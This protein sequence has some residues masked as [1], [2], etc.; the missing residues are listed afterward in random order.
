[1]PPQQTACLIDGGASAADTCSCWR[2]DASEW[3]F[4]FLVALSCRQAA[5]A[6]KI[7]PAKDYLT[8][9]NGVLMEEHAKGS[10]VVQHLA[11]AS[12]SFGKASHGDKLMRTVARAL[13]RPFFCCRR[14]QATCG[15]VGGAA[16]G[17]ARERQKPCSDFSLASAQHIAAAVAAAPEAEAFD[18]AADQV[19]ALAELEALAVPTGKACCGG[20]WWSAF[21]CAVGCALVPHAVLERR[22]GWMRLLG[23]VAIVWTAIAVWLTAS[24]L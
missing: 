21:H 6:T 4:L 22:R 14:W 11:I 1:M 18:P 20:G 24:P 17:A 7:T 10:P 3:H 5:N 13:L 16:G 23:I 9:K 2:D 8:G 19:S 12:R 15:V